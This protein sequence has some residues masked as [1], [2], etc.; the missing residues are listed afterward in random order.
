MNSLCKVW[1]SV[2]NRSV[3]GFSQLTGN[4]LMGSEV[5][6]GVHL[7]LLTDQRISHVIWLTRDPTTSFGLN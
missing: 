5:F 6:L 7:T 4:A 1:S 2:G 3:T